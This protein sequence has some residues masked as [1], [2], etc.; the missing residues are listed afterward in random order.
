MTATEK[1]VSEAKK[2]VEEFLKSAGFIKI[3]GEWVSA[4]D[5]EADARN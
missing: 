1:F 3:N 5:A 4:D 2:S